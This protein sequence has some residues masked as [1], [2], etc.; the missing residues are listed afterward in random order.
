MIPTK[1]R[2]RDGALA[3]LALAAILV[4]LIAPPHGLLDKADRAAFA[5]CHRLPERTFHVAGRQLPLCAR[6]SGTYLGTLA[7]LT[8][9]MLRGRGRASGFPRP[10]YALVLGLFLL[11]WAVDGA[12][13]YLT[14]FPGLPHLYEPHNWLRLVTGT[15]QGLA[16]ASFLLPVV[17]LAFWA[18]PAAGRS[19]E[20]GADLAWL[21]V[22]GAVVVGLVTSEQ[23]FL[24]YPLALLSGLTI[25]ALF[26]LLNGLLVLMLLRREARAMRWGPLLAPLL[27]GGALALGEL[28]AIAAVRDWLTVRFA[29]PF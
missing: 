18:A 3:L 25:V 7:G 8:V 27:V 10:R 11:A 23:P 5:V 1:A 12:N 17:N 29:L 26:G 9:L 2:H 14:L 21:L 16:I 13:S 20:T 28:A 6:C 4:A 19:V 22:G 15:L 24:L